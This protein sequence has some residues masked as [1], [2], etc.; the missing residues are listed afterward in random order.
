MAKFQNCSEVKRL[1][2]HEVIYKKLM[3]PLISV[4][5]DE[6]TTVLLL[7]CLYKC[8]R[9]FDG[10]QNPSKWNE[11]DDVVEH[12]LQRIPFESDNRCAAILYLFVAKITLLQMKMPPIISNRLDI[13][14][15]DRTIR[16]VENCTDDESSEQ[17]DEL[18]TIFQMHHN[19]PIARWTKKLLEV[20]TQRAI[21]GRADEIRFQIHVISIGIFTKMH[22]EVVGRGQ[23][24]TEFFLFILKFENSCRFY[25]FAICAASMEIHC[26]F[27]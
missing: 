26:S 2:L 8:I 23:M 18:R 21:I 17:F 15:L 24:M 14:N 25:T 13:E 20:L 7:S 22:F 11:V 27:E 3:N 10:A 19:L 5:K 9:Q 4:L 1:N 6:D 16:H 12:I